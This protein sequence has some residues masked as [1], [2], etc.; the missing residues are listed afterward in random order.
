MSS[1]STCFGAKSFARLAFE[2]YLRT[3]RRS[4]GRI[5]V[6]FNPNHDPRN[7]QF[8]FGPGGAGGA[9]GTER[10]APAS[11]SRGPSRP[12]ARPGSFEPNPRAWIGGNGGPPLNDP[13]KIEQVFPQLIIAPAG[14]MIAVADN[15]LDLTGPARRMSAESAAIETRRLIGQIREIDPNYRFQ[16]LGAPNTT[17]GQI[18]QIRALRMDRAVR[19]YQMRGDIEPLQVETLRFVQ[20]RVDR[21]YEEGVAR[22]DAGKLPVRLSRNEAIGNFVDVRVRDELR[23][24]YKSANIPADRGKEIQVNRRATNSSEG[25]FS[26]PD[27]RIGKLA[28]DVSLTAKNIRTP[29]I[30]NFFRADFG[31]DA[32]VIVRPRQLGPGN[33]YMIT[34]PKGQ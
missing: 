33:T 7:G 15:L 4:G 28:I 30:Q 2:Q 20:D 9:A 16:S 23:D 17:E 32:V 5:Q 1:V 31:P 27:S 14:A 12:P 11:Q 29:Q 21:A 22:A 25:S 10:S 19:M 13:M 18:N 8:T 34:R 24:L 6:K 26:I 3:G